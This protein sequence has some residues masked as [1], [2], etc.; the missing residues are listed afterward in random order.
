MGSLITFLMLAVPLAII[1]FGNRAPAPPAP[2]ARPVVASDDG[3]WVLFP[4]QL[5][6]SLAGLC[7]LLLCLAVLLAPLA[8]VVLLILGA[9]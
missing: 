6:A 7:W 9:M 2:P 3:E 8:F 5:I 4:F 1:H